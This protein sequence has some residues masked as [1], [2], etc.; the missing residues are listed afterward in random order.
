M[1]LPGG[2]KY[3]SHGIF[4]KF[5]IDKSGLYGGDEFAMKGITS[6]VLIKLLLLLPIL[7]FISLATLH[8]MKGLVGYIDFAMQSQ[9]PYTLSFPIFNIIDYKVGLSATMRTQPNLFSFFLKKKGYRLSAVSILPVS[10]DTVYLC[11]HP[12][13][14]CVY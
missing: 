8:E 11:A 9:F 4:F 5:S 10:G 6:A 1:C 2:E 12:S 7:T 13:F 14:V 3:I